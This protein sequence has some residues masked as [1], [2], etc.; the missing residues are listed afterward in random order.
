MRYLVTAD[1][2]DSN[3]IQ[4]ESLKDYEVPLPVVIWP[5][6]NFTTTIE[7]ELSKM[8]RIHYDLKTEILI[9]DEQ[10]NIPKDVELEKRN[11]FDFIKYVIEKY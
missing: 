7:T 9:F 11:L 6:V 3:L 8:L 5:A 2:S 1:D 10:E 4:P